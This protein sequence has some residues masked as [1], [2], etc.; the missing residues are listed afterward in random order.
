[1]ATHHNGF[2]QW[3]TFYNT[4][5][6]I[7]YFSAQS[8]VSMHSLLLHF[9]INSILD[10]LNRHT[11]IGFFESFVYLTVHYIQNQRENQKWNIE[12]EILAVFYLHI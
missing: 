9:I 5:I 2:W 6:Y 11:N 4:W 7:L 8:F 1:M 12:M 3:Q 10:F